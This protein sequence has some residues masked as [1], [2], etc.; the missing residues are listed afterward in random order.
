MLFN[1]CETGVSEL[2]T[3]PTMW[4]FELPV[5]TGKSREMNWAIVQKAPNCID[6]HPL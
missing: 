2:Y 3:P 1:V 5:N 6:L 4:V